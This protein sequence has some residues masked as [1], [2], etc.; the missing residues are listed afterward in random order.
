MNVERLWQSDKERNGGLVAPSTSFVLS[1]E[2]ILSCDVV[3]TASIS[4]A[5]ASDGVKDLIGQADLFAH[6]NLYR[7]SFNTKNQPEGQTEG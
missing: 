3:K 5:M 1:T 6:T 2:R 7:P 4:F